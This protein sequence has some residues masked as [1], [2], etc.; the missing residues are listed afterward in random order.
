M[1][2]IL[3]GATVIGC[4]ST[5]SKDGSRTFHNV[6]VEQADD[7]ISFSCD[8]VIMS[9]IKKYEKYDF[10]VDYSR[11]VWDGKVQTYVRLVDVFK[12]AVS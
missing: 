7:V 1:K 2:F 11:S 9:K 8:P 3:Q 12:A 5:L 10:L 6:T 4:K